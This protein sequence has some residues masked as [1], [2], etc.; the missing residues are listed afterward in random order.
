MVRDDEIGDARVMDV[1]RQDHR[2]W[3]RTIVD[4][5]IADAE[6]DH[7]VTTLNAAD[8]DPIASIGCGFDF[9]WASLFACA[10]ECGNAATGGSRKKGTG[11]ASARQVHN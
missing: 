9:L 10:A 2:R 7:G 5:L 3:L 11:G 4:Q 8:L 1:Q 6:M